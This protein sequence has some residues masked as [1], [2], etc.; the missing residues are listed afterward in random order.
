[1]GGGTE[2]EIL[3]KRGGARDADHRP[4]PSCCFSL[5]SLSDCDGEV[6]A[7]GRGLVSVFGR[8]EVRLQLHGHHLLTLGLD[9]DG[10]DVRQLLVAGAEARVQLVGHRQHALARVRGAEEGGATG[11]AQRLDL[12]LGET[13]QTGREQ[14]FKH[15]AKH[16]NK[17]VSS[18]S[19]KSPPSGSGQTKGGEEGER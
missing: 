10:V 1:M 16:T 3:S 5:F 12:L 9:G 13:K 15:T 8:E 18:S 2:R 17:R 11:D 19:N 6:R 7:H 4:P 14:K